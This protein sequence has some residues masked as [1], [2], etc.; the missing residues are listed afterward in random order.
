MNLLK[1][2]RAAALVSAALLGTPAAAQ[3]DAPQNVPPEFT[4]NTSG[5]SGGAQIQDGRFLSCSVQRPY[6]EGRALFLALNPRYDINLGI[7]NPA[8]EL[9]EGERAT[10]RVKVD[11]S[12]Q[13]DFPAVPAGPKVMVIPVGAD[14]QLFE[15]LRRGAKLS[16]AVNDQNFEFA[17]TGTAASLNAVRAC[18]DKARELAGEPVGPQ[19]AQAGISREA[20]AALLERAGV[21]GV[22]FVRHEDLPDGVVQGWVVGEDVLGGV[23]Q[24]QRPGRE[25]QID[26][27]AD[28]FI[29][30]VAENCPQ[31]VE[32][33]EQPTEV[34]A[35]VYGV[36]TA[37]LRCA[38]GEHPTFM[39]VLFAL[40]DRYYS[41]F[42]H[43]SPF[44]QEEEATRA[45]DALA[46]VIRELARGAADQ[47]PA[48]G[49]ESAP[50]QPSQ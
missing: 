32:R 48:T 19:A 15:L 41:A 18:V 31:P 22:K 8:W 23:V 3:Q 33:V 43:Q 1:I 47:N 45:T 9:K 7:L 27:F 35:E 38:A 29:S 12:Y 11:G 10:A 34:I 21:K 46:N 40:D 20:M 26:D 28:E 42:F 44:E 36:K 39:A 25:V 5:W 17:L 49:G 6:D 14:G 50:E 2:F 16:V 4:I 37:K 13:K 30:A 24:Q